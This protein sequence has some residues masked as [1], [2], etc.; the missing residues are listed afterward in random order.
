MRAV[1]PGRASAPTMTVTISLVSST[2]RPSSAVTASTGVA[3]R[4]A[5]AAI[6]DRDPV[7]LADRP[8]VGRRVAHGA[9]HLAGADTRR[10]FGERGDV[11]DE[12]GVGVVADER[13][14]RLDDARR[15]HDLDAAIG[16]RVDLLRDGNDVLV[17]GQH[18]DALRRRR[19][20]RLEDL[21]RRRVHRLAAGDDDLHAEAREQPADA[22]AHRD[23]DDRGLDRGEGRDVAG[24]VPPAA[25]HS[26]SC[27][28]LL[29]QV[30]DPD[31]MRSARFDAGFDRGADVVGVDVAVPDAVAADDDDR[32]A[33]R[34]PRVL[35]RGDRRVG[36]VEQVHHLVA[37]AGD[38]VAAEVRLDRRGREP[39]RRLGDRPAVDDLEE[40]GASS[41]V[42]PLPPASTTPALA[43]HREQVGS[44]GDGGVG[45]LGRVREQRGEVAP[46][47][48]SIASAVS[49]TT[50]RIVP[51]TGRSTASYAASAARRIAVARSAGPSVVSGEH[52]SA[53]PRRICERITPELPRAPMSEPRDIAVH[54]SPIA[55][56]VASSCATDSR[57]SA[58]LVPVSPSGT[59]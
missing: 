23:R 14:E 54:T 45:G 48:A 44:A 22:V 38:V 42:K 36:R 58:M 29:E 49:R 46:G 50:V 57:V 56:A 28:D 30:G 13:G 40:R 21:R 3:R 39:Q 52:T 37:Q 53:T 25:T 10:R 15:R 47:S 12:V 31:L 18:D 32:V 19:L 2:S 20:D 33:E 5:D 8:E 41:S 34:A 35:E 27:V 6:V 9:G 17:V 11:G 43:Q 51:S 55:S 7:A 16:E 26:C 4:R 59:G 24:A 1:S